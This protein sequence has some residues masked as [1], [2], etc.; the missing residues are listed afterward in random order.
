M[1]A[2]DDSFAT[3]RR[4][5]Y[6]RFSAGIDNK[7]LPADVHTANA[8]VS[9]SETIAALVHRYRL[10]ISRDYRFHAGNHDLRTRQ[11]EGTLFAIRRDQ[12]KEIICFEKI[13][14]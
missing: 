4:N 3:H 10:Q 7:L 14:S 13:K 9:P 1:T 2:R 6:S 12:A 11:R 8:Q 5:V